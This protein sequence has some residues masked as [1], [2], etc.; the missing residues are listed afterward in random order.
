[1]AG[2]LSNLPNVKP[3]HVNIARL[4]TSALIKTLKASCS[5][6]ILFQVLIKIE[7]RRRGMTSKLLMQGNHFPKQL[8]RW[9]DQRD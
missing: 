4:T 7:Q 5:P 6:I 2:A 1:M 9:F 3:V 8:N